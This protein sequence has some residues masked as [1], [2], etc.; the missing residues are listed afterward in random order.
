MGT[1]MM[2][3]M[4]E[5]KL[6]AELFDLEGEIISIDPYGNGH[7]NKTL[8]LVTTKKRY[9]MQIMN[10]ILQITLSSFA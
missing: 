3:Y 8:L 5:Y 6:K 2:D 4:K 10:V 9:I 1:L 7:I